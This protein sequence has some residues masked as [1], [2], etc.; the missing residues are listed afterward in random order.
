M[1][2]PELFLVHIKPQLPDA[3]ERANALDIDRSW[4]V[5][6][7]AGSG[8]TGLLIQ[9]FLRLLADESVESPEQILAI[10]FTLKATAEMRER[11]FGQIQAAAN[12]AE[13]RNDF[14]RE[15]RPLAQGALTRDRELGWALLDQPRRLNIRTIDSVCSEIAS[16]LPLL[17]GSGGRRAPVNDAQP[18]YQLAARRTFLQLGGEDTELHQALHSILL[19]RDGNLAD[20]EKLLANM[21]ELREQWGELIPLTRP[22]L[23][24]AWLDANILPKLER[25]LDQVICAALTQLAETIPANLLAKVTSVAAE[26]AHIDGYNGKPSPIAICTSKFNSPARTA[27]DLAHWRALMHLLVSPSQESWRKGFNKNQ[28]GFETTK[29]EREIL[30]PL[31]DGLQENQRL[32]DAIRKLGALPPATY[33]PEQW[34]VA[35]ALFCILNRALAELQLVF[36]E[37]G[38]CDFTELALAAKTALNSTD[39]ARDLEAALGIHLQHLLVDEMQDTSSS[40]YELIQTLTQ[41]WDGHSQTVFLVGDPKQSI[42]LFRQAR[43]ERFMR[44]MRSARLGDIPLGCLRLTANF[45]SQAALVDEFNKDFE[46]I[47]PS[48]A[49]ALHTEEVPYVGA[50]AMRDSNKHVSNR[51]WHT[52]VLASSTDT[53]QGKRDKLRQRTNDAEEIRKI[54]AYWREQPLPPGR[55]EPWKIAVLVR[56]RNHLTEVIAA[57]KDRRNGPPVPFR[58]VE[59]EPL[60]ER[61]EVQDLFALTRALL[62]PA[63]RTA[64]LAVLHAPWCGFGLEELHV[65]TGADDPTWA[66]RTIQFALVERGDLLGEEAL[67]RL[68][69][70]WPVLEAATA[71]SGRLPIVELV[72]RTWRSLGGDAYCG[73]AE[74]TNA[75]RYLQLLDEVEDAAGTLDLPLLERRLEKLFATPIIHTG[76]VDLLTIHKSKGLEWDVVIVPAL[77]RIGARDRSRLLNWLELDSGDEQAAQVLLSPTAG[78]GDNSSAE[79]YKWISSV[80]SARDAAERMRLFY[81]ACTRAREELHLFAA[82]TMSA[83]GEVA[84][85]FGSL[86]D[87]AWQAAEPHF[88]GAIARQ[89]SAQQEESDDSER[90]DEAFAIA[91]EAEREPARTTMLKRL[92]LDFNPATRFANAKPL[93]YGDRHDTSSAPHFER[94]EGSTTAR[95]FGN[96]IHALIE[97]ITADIAAGA[98]A[99]AIRA[100]LPTW[101]PRVSAVLRAE[102]LQPAVV[103]RLAQRVL[104]ALENTLED[105]VGQWLLSPHEGAA[106]EFALTAWAQQRSSIRVDRIFRGGSE[107]LVEGSGYFWV[108]DYKTTTH[109]TEDVDAL[110]AAERAKYAP[111]LETYARILAEANASVEIR[112]ALYYP[113]L[114]RFVWWRWISS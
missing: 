52:S 75:T 33:P 97:K 27:N 47:F 74:L 79:L 39:G 59:I 85:L 103:E 49:S 83:K 2:V 82:P 93:P 61:P 100:A 78:K 34:A 80:N 72:E 62:H 8:K 9:R 42:Y 60:K 70:I 94:P 99:D 32:L 43:V 112:L 90:P 37:R 76:A 73:A 96:A 101:T 1:P 107:P 98:T 109:D 16:S 25:A 12:D 113:M 13:P 26:M 56:S 53:A 86:L 67:Q 71:L 54:I 14:D 58:A 31:V 18:L 66:E 11:V 7:P 35:K 55:K 20:C 69:R 104:F 28:I 38:E 87:S 77:E 88:A 95:A 3:E 17:S 91:A 50:V 68:Q 110:L 89:A 92:P 36:A 81:V 64:W 29:K 102:G 40:Q 23:E 5:E 24:D 44:T 22:R 106:T 45:R 21:L 114:A 4:I 10:T 51:V 84:H 48:A 57:F 19:H 46:G 65:L 108:I 15:T 105:S 111:Q 63:D 6:A 30:K 41:G